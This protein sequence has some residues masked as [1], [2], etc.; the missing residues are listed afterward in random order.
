[1]LSWKLKQTLTNQIIGRA[2]MI[3]KKIEKKTVK[4]K[5]GLGMVVIIPLFVL[6][7]IAWIII[8]VFAEISHEIFWQYVFPKMP[9]IMEGL[10]ALLFILFLAF[11][12]G[13]LYYSDKAKWMAGTIDR[14]ICNLPVIKFFWHKK[15]NQTAFDFSKMKGAMIELFWDVWIIVF[16]VGRQE[17]KYGTFITV[18]FPTV[19]LPFTGILYMFDENNLKRKRKIRYLKNPPTHLSNLFF[20]RIK[21]ARIRV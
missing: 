6:A 3:E 17:T 8:K 2:M 21:F 19:P 11:G 5:I 16:I 20:I 10:S 12:L 15:G 9:G 14:I 1:M 18:M 7:Y 4:S 13:A